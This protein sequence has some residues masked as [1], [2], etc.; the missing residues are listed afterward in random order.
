VLCWWRLQQAPGHRL[1]E[2]SRGG[3]GL[4]GCVNLEWVVR[5]LLGLFV[6][7]VQAA[8][9]GGVQLGQGA[10]VLLAHLV[11]EAQSSGLGRGPLP[12]TRG[13]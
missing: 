10:V 1:G 12:L 6:P 4:F 3:W 5:V 7:H 9:P 11:Q 13:L 2:W 8:M